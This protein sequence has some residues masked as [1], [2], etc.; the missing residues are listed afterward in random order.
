MSEIGLVHF[1]FSLVA[2]VSGGAVSLMRKGT[3]WHRTVGHIYVTSML[4]LIVTAFSIFG[5]LGHFGP[6]HV[7]AIVSTVTIGLGMAAVLLRKPKGAWKEQHAYWM[8]WSYIGL[9]A[10]AVAETSTR[11]ILPALAPRL[12]GGGWTIFWSLVGGSTFLVVGIGV[13]ITKTR[14]PASLQRLNPR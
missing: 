3:R 2:I 13:W 9:M 12:E 8:A 14:L 10:A 6:F 11:F 4:G 1:V 7:A 5:L